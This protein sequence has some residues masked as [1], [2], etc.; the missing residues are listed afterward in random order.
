MAEGP[1]RA[2]HLVTG[3][4]VPYVEQ[5]DPSGVPVLLLHPWVESM[6]CFDRVLPLLPSALHVLAW[7]QLVTAVR[8]SRRMATT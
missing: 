1:R 3:V 2:V 6:G 8:T 7:D 4:S 5:G